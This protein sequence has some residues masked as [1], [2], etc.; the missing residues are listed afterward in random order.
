MHRSLGIVVL[1]VVLGAAALGGGRHAVEA[2]PASSTIFIPHILGNHCGDF[3]DDFSRAT[4]WFEGRR[5]GLLAELRDGEYRLSVTQPGLVWLVGAPDCARVNN[6]VAVTVRWAGAP[7]NFY[8]LLFGENGRAGNTYM[9]VVNSNARV[10]LLLRLDNG[11]L[12]MVMGP[13]GDDAIAAGAAHNRL[14]IT[15]G[16]GRILL[17]INDKTV[18][19]LPDPDPDTPIIT[20]L[21]AAS[22]TD[23]VP[24][25]ARFD[26]FVHRGRALGRTDGA[27]SLRDGSAWAE[28]VSATLP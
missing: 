11:S 6:Q 14:A 21:V 7:G 26:D 20:G 1:V 24:A 27:A 16:S 10:W 23:H 28:P 22:Y 9:L 18:G 17:A 13:T 12:A 5:D 3:L 25:D 19:Q 8:G 15:R 2:S 4:G